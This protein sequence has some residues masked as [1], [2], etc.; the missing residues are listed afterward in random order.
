MR[1]VT[2]AERPAIQ[3]DGTMVVQ[4]ELGDE[5]YGEA[6]QKSFIPLAGRTKLNGLYS[7]FNRKSH[8]CN[9]LVAH[10]I[11]GIARP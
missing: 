3:R 4:L 10:R 2:F 1:S 9:T 8:Q 6:T 7:A 11:S 5:S